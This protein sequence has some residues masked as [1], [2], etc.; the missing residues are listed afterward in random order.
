MNLHKFVHIYKIFKKRIEK[1]YLFDGDMS[2][3]SLG[4][5][6]IR[7]CPNSGEK[8]FTYSKRNIL[9]LLS[10]GHVQNV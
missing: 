6:H 1:D 2:R 10:I 4:N 3:Q 7:V 9:L 8:T 5:I